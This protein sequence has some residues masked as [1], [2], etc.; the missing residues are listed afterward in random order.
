LTV[1][2]ADLPLS[3]S[4]PGSTPEAGAVSSISSATARSASS[5]LRNL[6]IMIAFAHDGDATWARKR[7]KTIPARKSDP[8]K[9]QEINTH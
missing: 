2:A 5:L 6:V 4:G 8:D 9:W 7:R 3:R 1:A